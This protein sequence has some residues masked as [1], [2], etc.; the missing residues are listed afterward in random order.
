MSEKSTKSLK[1]TD[2]GEQ[3]SNTEVDMFQTN[4]STDNNSVINETNMNVILSLPLIAHKLTM[5]PIKK[6]F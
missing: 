5:K 6:I 4:N 2:N 3:K 1:D